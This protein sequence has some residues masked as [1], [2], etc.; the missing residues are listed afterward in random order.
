MK[1]KKQK[2]EKEQKEITLEQAKRYRLICRIAF[3]IIAFAIPVIITCFKFKLFTEYTTAKLSVVGILIL[4]IIAWRF[5]NKLYE[6]INS[7]ENSNIMKHVLL[8]IGR[9]WPFLLMIV[10]IMALKLS[11]NKLI[12]DALFCLEWTCV[13]ELIS[14]IG[15]YP[16]EMKMDYLVKRMLTKQERKAD[17][18]EA[19]KEMKEENKPKGE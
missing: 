9:V 16:I 4:V 19:I 11:A 15:I 17:Y 8:G 13:C 5:K 14:Y 1:D 3:F 10:L 6:W 2:E 12:D 18:K 7:W